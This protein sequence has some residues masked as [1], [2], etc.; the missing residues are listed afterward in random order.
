MVGSIFQHTYEILEKNKDFIDR[1]S[2]I[3][4]EKETLKEAEILD[5]TQKMYRVGVN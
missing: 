1:C 5:L 4:L 2:K 3:L